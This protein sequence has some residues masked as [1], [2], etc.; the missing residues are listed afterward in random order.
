[1]ASEAS[2]STQSPLLDGPILRS[3]LRVAIPVILSNLLQSLYG[4]ID[5]FWVGRLGDNAVAAISISQPIN[6]L[7]FALGSGLSVAGSTLIAQHIGARQ[8]AQANHI[9]AQSLL[10]AV[11]FAAILMVLGQWAAPLLITW[12]HAA[13]A[14]YDD[15]VS[16]L[17]ITL[18]GIVFTFGFA[19]VQSLMRGAGQVRV[20]LFIVGGTV[21]LNLVIDPPLIFGWGPIPALGVPGAAIATL[22][23]QALAL[24][25]GLAVLSSKRIA[26][27]VHLKDLKPDPGA[28][29]H[30]LRLGVPSS[31][32]L[33]ARALGANGMMFLIASFGTI[34]TAA[35]GVVNNI[36]LLVIIPGLGFSMANAALVG[37]NIGA[38]QIERAKS[39]GRLSAILAFLSLSLVGLIM[40]VFAYWII[41]LFIPGEQQVIST[42]E[43]FL[44]IVAP[45]YGLIGLQMALA[46]IF[47]AAGRT[48]ITMKLALISQWLVQLPLA[49]LLSLNSLLGMTGLWL[50]FPL[51]NILMAVITFVW[52]RRLD[53]QKARLVSSQK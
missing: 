25:G 51:T 50:A 40:F 14:V 8:H 31:I 2:S 36:N 17:R 7:A 43:H 29:W 6:F 30:A 47:R 42:A 11:A 10:M 48:V 21:L 45:S 53:W 16:F 52:Y 32:E 38:G 26:I 1:M 39:I 35:Y 19:M 20:P 34:T 18:G 44:H 22:I 3:L 24:A 37:Q 41:A 15:A 23:T 5:A 12:F 27:S 46:G 9:A 28:I 49:W 4:T 13:P 33:S